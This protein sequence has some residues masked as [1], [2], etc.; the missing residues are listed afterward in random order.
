MKRYNGGVDV[1]GSDKKRPLT[2][3]QESTGEPAVMDHPPT[4]PPRGRVSLSTSWGRG[5]GE[6]EVGRYGLSRSIASCLR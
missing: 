4:P 1:N 2:E 6:E 5:K 3:A